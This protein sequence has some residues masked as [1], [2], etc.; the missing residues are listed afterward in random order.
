MSEM[1]LGW[2]IIRYTVRRLRDTGF[3]GTHDNRKEHMGRTL[4]LNRNS[5]AV[6][7]EGG[8]LIVRDH[9]AE[10]TAPVRVPLAD[11]ERVIVSGQPAIS[12]PAIAKMMDEKIPCSFMTHGGRWRGL[13][14]GDFGFHADR[15]RRQYESMGDDDFCMRF[16]A[17]VV[18]A[19]LK[20]SRRTLLRLAANRKTTLDGNSD[21]N[22]LG[23]CIGA[24]PYMRTVDALRGLEGSAASCYFRTLARFFPD[25]AP[26]ETRTRRPPRDAANA[27]LSFV[28]TLLANEVVAA[29][30]A[31]GLDVAAGYFHRDR[32]RSPSL[33]LDL[34][35]PYRPALADRLALDLLNH[36]RIRADRHFHELETG[37]VHLTDEGRAVVFRAF[38]DALA[39]RIDTEAGHVTMRQQIDRDVCSFLAMLE[40]SETPRFYHAA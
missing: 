27:L 14:D 8:H 5:I 2:R 39:R 24:M 30:R 1:S 40:R 7:L 4:V 29:V 22:G 6:S 21:W 12:F 19:K 15:R 10:D 11:V 31:H 13:M 34:M 20:N 18:E 16:T 28:Y 32:D 23:K 36:G 26:F 37:G 17:R 38:D 3:C 9:A 25:D 35:E 33:A